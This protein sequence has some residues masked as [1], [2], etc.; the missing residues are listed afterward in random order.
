MDYSIDASG[1]Q[2]G[3]ILDASF[4]YSACFPKFYVVVKTTGRTIFAEEIGQ[5]IVTSDAYG[6][7][8]TVVPDVSKRSGKIEVAR[9]RKSGM[10]RLDGNYT[11]RWDGKPVAFYGD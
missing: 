10:I 11:Y 9:I 6:Q 5:K 1:F 4:R 7:S 2:P 3:D 8:G